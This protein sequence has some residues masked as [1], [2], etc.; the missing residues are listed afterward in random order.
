LSVSEDP[1]DDSP[2]QEWVENTN[3]LSF[4]HFFELKYVKARMVLNSNDREEIVMNLKN[5]VEDQMIAG[6]RW[7]GLSDSTQNLNERVNQVD[8]R[9]LMAA[10]DMTDV[11]KRLIEKVISDA[12]IQG[13]ASSNA[14]SN[15]SSH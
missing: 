14:E 3:G 6:D 1:G 11:F 10:L 4:A 2:L 9:V 5:Y 7:G 15:A 13:G 8:P 12:M